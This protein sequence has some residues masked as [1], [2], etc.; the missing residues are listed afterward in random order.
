[1]SSRHGSVEGETIRQQSPVEAHLSA[2]RASMDA[3]YRD[4]TGLHTYRLAGAVVCGSAPSVGLCIADP[5]V[6]RLHAEFEVRDD[7]V[8]VRDLGSR[9]GTYVDGIRVGLARLPDG[10]QVTVGNTVV[11]CRAAD[12]PLPVDLWPVPRFGPL[13]GQ[14]QLMRELFSRLSRY[15]STESSVLIQGETGT[16]KE[17]VASAIHESSP[18]AAGPFVIV[19]CGGLPE[20]LLES[21]L[22]GHARGAFTGAVKARSGA[23]EDASGGTVFL[24]EVGELPLSMQPKLLR[25]LESRT[26]RRLGESAHRPVDV[27][28]VAATHR[29]LQSMVASGAFREDLYFRLAVLPLTLPPLRSRP[30]DI[31]VLVDHFSKGRS[32]EMTGEELMR[33]LAERPWLGNVRELRN[34]VERAMAIGAREAM[35]LGASARSNPPA[36]TRSA[37]LPPVPC[38]RPFKELREAWIEHFDREYVRQLLEQHGRDVGAAANTAGV[39]RTYIYRLMRRHGL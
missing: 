6:S 8:W 25:V 20:N 10:A 23:F 38:D 32:L 14:S 9:N 17:L 21:E 12:S 3:S 26:V 4:A 33:D 13:L 31:P 29:D 24:D 18:R 36:S 1:M 37:A 15:A 30:E 28:F 11:V 16:G 39:D 5:T 35:S 2:T 27:R 19:D 22:F 7:G 34:F